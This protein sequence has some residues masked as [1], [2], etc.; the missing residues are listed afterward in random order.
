MAYKTNYIVNAL[1]R[2][3][4]SPILLLRESLKSEYQE[5]MR[6]QFPNFESVDL[7]TQKITIGKVPAD[8][9]EEIVT[10][11]LWSF[12]NKGKTIKIS[13]CHNFFI[14]EFLKYFSFAEFESIIN[15]TFTNFK[16]YYEPIVCK[17]FGLR[18]INNIVL[19]EGDPLIW[20]GYLL[21]FLT[22]TIEDF[23]LKENLA[24]AINQFVVNMDNCKLLINS[25]IPNNEYPSKINRKEFLLDIDC[26]SENCDGEDPLNSLKTFHYTI[27]DFFE[28]CIDDKLRT[29]MGI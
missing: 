28:K 13:L 6:V 7:T 8:K 1:F 24:R 25:G 16:R 5:S 3:D 12:F 27:E 23:P 18:Y 22:K 14:V 20:S 21:P 19:K 26:F 9:T 4:F 17:R 11:K 29:L 10:C 15:S 2:I